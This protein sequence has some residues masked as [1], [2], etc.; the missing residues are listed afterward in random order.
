MKIRKSIVL[1]LHKVANKYLN[2]R[3]TK[4]AILD[5]SQGCGRGKKELMNL[6]FEIVLFGFLKNFLFCL[7]S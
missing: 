6:L 1:E 7:V 3:K 4:F 2:E 5:I